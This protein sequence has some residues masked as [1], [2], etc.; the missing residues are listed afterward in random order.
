MELREV[1]KFGLSVRQL[2][3]E[4]GYDFDRLLN[5]ELTYPDHFAVDICYPYGVRL[6]DP[7]RLY[8]DEKWRDKC[9]YTTWSNEPWSDH[10]PV[11]ASVCPVEDL[12]W[13]G[14]LKRWLHV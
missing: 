8:G 4:A 3:E 2:V 5:L 7:L 13:W 14:R 6:R 9:G 11:S 1:E 12:N 10:V